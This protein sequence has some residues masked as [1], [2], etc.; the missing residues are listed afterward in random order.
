MMSSGCIA[1]HGLERQVA[2]LRFTDGGGWLAGESIAFL[3]R[4]QPGESP[5]GSSCQPAPLVSRGGGRHDVYGGGDLH[6]PIPFVTPERCGEVF[7]DLV[8]L[9]RASLG[10][11]LGKR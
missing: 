10:K 11:K 8:A 2:W 1:T 5:M 3:G 6:H 7:R 9:P 4:E